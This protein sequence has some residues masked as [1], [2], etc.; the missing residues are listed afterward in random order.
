MH[1][2]IVM[3]VAI[4]SLA[5][6]AGAT[7]QLEFTNSFQFMPYSESGFTVTGTG[8]RTT[9]NL[10]LGEAQNSVVTATLAQTNGQ[11]F[12]LLS[13]TSVLFNT[14]SADSLRVIS[15]TGA[16]QSMPFNFGFPTFSG[17]DWTNIT[18]VQ[19]ELTGASA[20]LTTGRID[21]VVLNPVPAPGAAA[22]LGGLGVVSRRRRPRC[23]H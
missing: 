7:V 2:A 17:P 13:L 6:V 9:S 8:W 5:P 18:F 22:L 1:R 19:F 15:S 21:S 20:S 11:P 4:A 23:A 12:D 14:S 10:L 16:S 3:S